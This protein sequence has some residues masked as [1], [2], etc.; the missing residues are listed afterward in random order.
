MDPLRQKSV[1]ECNVV[2]SLGSSVSPAEHLKTPDSNLVQTHSG[3]E[4][5]ERPTLT[6]RSRGETCVSQLPALLL[7]LHHCPL[8]LESTHAQVSLTFSAPCGS[9]TLGP[10]PKIS[11][12]WVV[13]LISIYSIRWSKARRPR[14][15]AKMLGKG[16]GGWMSV[17]FSQ[18]AQTEHAHLFPATSR[19]WSSVA[20]DTSAGI[21]VSLLSRMQNTVRLQH[22]PICNRKE[23]TTCFQ[24]V[25]LFWREK[26][27]G[28]GGGGG[29]TVAGLFIKWHGKDA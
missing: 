16:E 24:V 18:A 25:V 27:R 23:N 10:R 20:C 29:R 22:P 2:Y 6:Y 5:T 19:T 21:R 1:P 11:W 12:A 3:S 26:G 17:S 14:R 15:T 9:I 13:R 4:E 7:P 8:T 28:A